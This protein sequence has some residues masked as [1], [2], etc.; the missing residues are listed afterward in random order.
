MQQQSVKWGTTLN[1]TLSSEMRMTRS[2]VSIP[3]LLLLL[4]SAVAAHALETAPFATKNEREGW[5]PWTANSIQPPPEIKAPK[6][7]PL[8]PQ[9]GDGETEL[10]LRSAIAWFETAI[11]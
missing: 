9:P 2:H 3:T 5:A 4:L 6:L 7:P 1:R 11:A 8:S 10:I